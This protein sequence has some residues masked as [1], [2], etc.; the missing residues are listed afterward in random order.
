MPFQPQ[1]EYVA[2]RR[3]EAVVRAVPLFK[4]LGEVEVRQ[5]VAALEPFAAPPGS[6][7]VEEGDRNAKEMYLVEGGARLFCSIKGLN[8]GAHAWSTSKVHIGRG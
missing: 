3:A 8:G 2:E 1:V 6:T 7:V 4:S 5:L